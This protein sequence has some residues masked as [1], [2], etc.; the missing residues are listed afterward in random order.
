L[1]YA[2]KYECTV[3]EL[4]VLPGE[5]AMIARAVY[6]ETIT[7]NRGQKIFEAL[8]KRERNKK[9]RD[10]KDSKALLTVL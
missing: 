10:D 7:A 8:I 9:E 4:G 1:R 6:E 5:V 3:W 2:K